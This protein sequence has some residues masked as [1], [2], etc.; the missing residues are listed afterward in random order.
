MSNQ[1]KSIVCLAFGGT[2]GISLLILA[3]AQKQ[4]GVW[5]PMFVVVFYLLA[6]LPRLVVRSMRSAS[7]THRDAAI[8]FSVGMVLS[9]FALPIVLQHASVIHAGATYLT[10]AANILIFVTISM[11]LRWT[12]GEADAGWR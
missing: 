8:F 10:M 4:Y 9:S 1:L 11:Y 12:E 6:L 2:L 7:S 3:C 5:W